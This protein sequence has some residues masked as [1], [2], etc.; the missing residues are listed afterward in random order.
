MDAPA[1]TALLTEALGRSLGNSKYGLQ[2]GSVALSESGKTYSAGMLASQTHLLDIPSELAAL[3][4]A[5]HANDVRITEMHTLIDTP[6][7]VS[8]VVL[9]LLVDH[10][11]RTGLPIRYT[12]RTTHGEIFFDTADVRVALPWYT[13]HQARLSSL[14]LREPSVA[15][16]KLDTESRLSPK[17]QLRTWALQGRDRNF[18]TRDGASSYG[19]AVLTSTGTMYF[20]GQ[21]STFEHRLGVHAEMGVLLDALMDGA[22]DVTHI[23][24]VSS[25]HTDT[26]CSPCGCCRQL[27]AEM[28]H[29]FGFS[30]EFVLFASETETYATSTVDELLPLQWSN[31]R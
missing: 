23:G 6:Q 27:V 26:P 4:R 20:G 2:S 16:T 1:L 5:T 25:K 14:E 17:L 29:R 22:R 3:V 12:I 8:P 30:P 11:V 13:P 15:R 21:Y 10:S 9:K 31:L 24:V 28:S 18:P 7:P 19:A